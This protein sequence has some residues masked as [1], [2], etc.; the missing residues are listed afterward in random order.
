M[1]SRLT[2]SLEESLVKR[3]TSY[4][5][6]HGLSLSEVVRRCFEVLPGEDPDPELTPTVRSLYG[7]LSPSNL[8]RRKYRKHL[9]RK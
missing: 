7:A 3:A 2:L 8:K 6:R 5:R 9:E 4:A 1:K